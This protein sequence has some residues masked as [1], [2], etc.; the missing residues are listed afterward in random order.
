MLVNLAAFS[1]DVR[2]L[3]CVGKPP[4]KQIAVDYVWDAGTKLGLLKT[5]ANRSVQAREKSQFV[6]APRWTM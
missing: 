2:D 1:S 6:V 3:H 5:Q 4:V